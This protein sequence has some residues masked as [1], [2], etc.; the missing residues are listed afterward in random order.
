M[1]TV[2]K[3]TV[4]PD[5]GQH[6]L[7]QMPGPEDVRQA[8]LEMDFPQ[9]GIKVKD[10]A[11]I[12]AETF[13]LSDEQTRARNSSNLNLFRHNVVSP[14]F[15]RLLEVGKLKQPGGPGTPYLLAESS[16]DL[17]DIELRETSLEY[18][19]ASDVK[20]VERT[21]VDPDTGEECLIELPSTRVV[22]EALLD[23]DYPVGGIEIKDIAEALADQFELSDKEKKARGK[24]GL[25]WRRH[26]NVAANSLVNSEK[27]LGIK[28]GWFINPD[29]PDVETSDLDGDSPFSDGETPSPEAVIEQ[30]YRDH[31]DRLKEDLLQEIMN[32]P[33][34]FFEELVLDL[35]FKMGYCD[36]RAD[37]EAIGRSGD[38]GIDGIIN[39]DPLGLDAIYV[40]AKQWTDRKVR[41][42]DIREFIGA[43]TNTGALKGV[44]ITTSKF[45][46]AAQ[47][48]ADE[49][50]GPKIVII[51]GKQ[52][53]PL[54]I[55]HDVGVSAGKSYQLKE[56]NMAYFTIDD[57]G[58]ND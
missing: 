2:T 8:I 39:Q 52:L 43:L 19:E 32:N 36:S 48:A 47:E 51:E 35:L 11:R 9:G 17:S 45:T 28:R 42:S 44:F 3:R 50:A 18:R 38:G 41:P 25:I 31:L 23:F 21:T 56:V 58:E 10:A 27:L 54:M 30:N 55:D 37:A 49:A 13:S 33:P 6:Y 22:K 29:Q 57:T 16:S 24:Y 53:V 12:L 15:K 34:E 40:Q 46:P 4:N 5:T 20:T 26:V 1:K 14:Q 7:I